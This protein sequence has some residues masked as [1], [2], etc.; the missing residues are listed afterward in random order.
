MQPTINFT[1]KHMANDGR[2]H[3]WTA[4][5][6]TVHPMSGIDMNARPRGEQVP[7]ECISF[8]TG[9]DIE[10]TID[11]GMVYILSIEGKNI[12][13]VTLPLTPHGNNKDGH[14][15]RGKL[16]QMVEDGHLPYLG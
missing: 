5:S 6:V 8:M 11:T 4:K 7:S 1:L 9:D 13:K 2:V 10:C 16:K 14:I 12:D 3:Y 15:T